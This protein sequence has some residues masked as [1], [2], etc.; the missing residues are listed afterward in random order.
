MSEPVIV[1]IDNDFEKRYFYSARQAA[2]GV[3]GWFVWPDNIVVKRG[4][5]QPGKVLVYR[6]DEEATNTLNATIH[7]EPKNVDP[8]NTSNWTKDTYTRFQTLIRNISGIKEK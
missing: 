2:R 1:V 6:L 3:L 5:S 7:A 8:K 4:Y